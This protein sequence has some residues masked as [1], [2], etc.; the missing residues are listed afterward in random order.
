MICAAEVRY[1]DNSRVSANQTFG[2][3][4]ILGN[5]G[6]AG[7]N[8]IVPHKRQDLPTLH[9]TV[10]QVRSVS[11][12]HSIPLTVDLAPTGVQ[13]PPPDGTGLLQ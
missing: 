12:S 5:L 10:L 4:R 13:T 2:E 9:L 8:D 11:V 7:A 3:T 1:V 6:L